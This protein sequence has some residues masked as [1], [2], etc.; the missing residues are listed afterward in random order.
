MQQSFVSSLGAKLFKN[1]PGTSLQDRRGSTDS[2]GFQPPGRSRSLENISGEHPEI[3]PT[4]SELRLPE[5]EKWSEIEMLKT[6]C[7]HVLCI[8]P[9]MSLDF[10]ASSLLAIGAT[11]LVPEGEY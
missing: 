3:P 6:L 5:E 7:P 11:A 2:M 9:S 1:R 8:L 10:V 4:I